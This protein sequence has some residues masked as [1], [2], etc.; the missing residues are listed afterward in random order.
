[1]LYWYSN[2]LIILFNDKVSHTIEFLLIRNELLF[3]FIRMIAI[4]F[5]SV[6]YQDQYYVIL[7]S[8][9]SRRETTLN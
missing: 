1:M 9:K 3:Q 7:Y 8:K 2:G 4:Y 5:I 6:F